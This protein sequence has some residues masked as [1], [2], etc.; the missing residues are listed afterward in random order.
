MVL[1][2]HPQMDSCQVLPFSKEAIGPLPLK[3][4]VTKKHID[5]ASTDVAYSKALKEPN[6]QLHVRTN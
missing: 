5:R 2:P 3:E 1:L 6:L 4:H